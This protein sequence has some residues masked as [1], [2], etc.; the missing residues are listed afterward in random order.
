MGF[1]QGAE[2]EFKEELA[3][4]ICMAVEKHAPNKKWHVDTV[5]KVLTLAGQEVKENYVCSLITLIA[6]TSELQNYAVE[7]TYFLM[8]EN[9]E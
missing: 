3:N 6:S 2:K 5:L 1:L 4:K 9:L 7:K 8:K